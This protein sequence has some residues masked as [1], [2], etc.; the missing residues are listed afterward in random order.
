MLRRSATAVLV[1]VVGC[2][3]GDNEIAVPDHGEPPALTGELL[4]FETTAAVA[5]NASAL[6]AGFT[7][8]LET[9]CAADVTRGFI[10]E[11][12]DHGFGDPQVA[13]EW[14]PVVPG[15]ASAPPIGQPEFF[16]SGTVT[17][18]DRSG[19]DFR[20]SH[21]FGFDTTWDF[22][23]DAPFLGL[24][25]NRPGDSNDGDAIHAEIESGLYPDAQFGIVPTA[26]DRVA[27][28]GAW[29]LDCGHPPY[30]AEIHP[31]TFL[32]VARADG[33]DTVALAFANPYR[34]SQLYGLAD[35]TTRFSDDMRFSPMDGMPFI[36]ALT[37]EVIEAALGQITQFELHDLLEA[38]H[39]DPVTWFVCAPPRPSPSAQLRYSFRFVARSGVKISA[40]TRGESGCLEFHAEAGSGYTPFVP[41][42]LDHL[43]TWPEINSE[44]SSQAGTD[45]DV[46]QLIVDAVMQQGF[47]GDAVA[48]R[49]ETATVVDEYMPLQPRG[50]AD[51]DSPTAVIGSA[52]DQPFPFYGRV[53]VGWR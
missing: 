2:S 25:H 4:G 9:V 24:I 7:G 43:W 1:L 35:D 15:P 6:P 29:I 16:A 45:V 14:A 17:D 31:P 41:E 27:M 19:L 12:I 13:Y 3:Y 38:T 51:A 44:A 40:A 50:S 33:A 5:A 42:R 30:E 23:V 37:N 48:L 11:L 47:P 8:P 22:R 26:G 36:R 53:R 52:N 20:P 46:R 18:L 28:K 21:P 49:P 10:A 34:S 32:A 39:L